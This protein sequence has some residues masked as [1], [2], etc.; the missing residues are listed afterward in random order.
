[1]IVRIASGITGFDSLTTA[2]DDLGFGVRRN[3]REYSHPYLW[4]SRGGQIQFLS[5]FCL[6]WVNTGMNLAFT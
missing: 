5:W 3:P 2:G 4:P 1:M 6:L